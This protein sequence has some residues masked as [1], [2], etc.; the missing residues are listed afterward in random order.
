[1]TLA[2]RS[3]RPLAAAQM[4]NGG[5]LPPRAKMAYRDTGLSGK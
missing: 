2:D 4:T 3:D 1:M 5:A